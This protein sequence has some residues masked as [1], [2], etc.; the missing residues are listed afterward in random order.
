MRLI[1]SFQT[2]TI[3]GRSASTR[4]SLAGSWTSAGGLDTPNTLGAPEHDAPDEVVGA[5]LQNQVRPRARR[6]DVVEQ[7]GPVRALPDRLGDGQRLLVGELRV[8]VEV[9]L[10]ALEGAVAQREEALEVPPADVGLLR[11][12]VER[13]VDEVGHVDR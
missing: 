3:H 1:G 11:V 6:L 2:I 4:S 9:G 7:V 13:E 8:A 12:E 5:L 10:G